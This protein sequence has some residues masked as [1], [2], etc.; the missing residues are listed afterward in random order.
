MPCQWLEP[1][2]VCS[3]RLHTYLLPIWPE[4][5]AAC[6]CTFCAVSCSSHSLK[7]SGVLTRFSIGCEAI[8]SKHDGNTVRQINW[9]R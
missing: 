3:R 4:T 7:S 2:L 1:T 5:C 9:V 6:T 8:V